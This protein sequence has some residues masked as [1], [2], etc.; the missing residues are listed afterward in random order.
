MSLIGDVVHIPVPIMLRDYYKCLVANIPHTLHQ[1]TA[2]K[3]AP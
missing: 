2:A 1:F 3:I